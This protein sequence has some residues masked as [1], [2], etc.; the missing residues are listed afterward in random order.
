[1]PNHSCFQAFLFLQSLKLPL[2]VLENELEPQRSERDPTSTKPSSVSTPRPE[3]HYVKITGC[4]CRV[5][6]MVQKT[7]GQ[8][9]RP[10]LCFFSTK[11]TRP[12]FRNKKTGRQLGCRKN[13][14]HVLKPRRNGATGYSRSCAFACPIGLST[15]STPGKAPRIHGTIVYLPT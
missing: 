2:L 7:Q 1:M 13:H 8:G 3:G 15:L 9:H 4:S 12:T 14:H 11:P 6:L 10:F 5:M